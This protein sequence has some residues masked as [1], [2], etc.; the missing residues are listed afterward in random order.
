MKYLKMLREPKY[1]VI[2]LSPGNVIVAPEIV[3]AKVS[4]D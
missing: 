2:K 3:T 1:K 4:A